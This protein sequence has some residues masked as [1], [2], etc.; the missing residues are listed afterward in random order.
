MKGIIL[1]AGRGSRLK[2]LTNNKPKCLVKFKGQ[3]LLDGIINNFLYNKIKD[4]YVVTG[5]REKKIKSSLI[6]KIYNSK[7]NK[8][9]IFKSLICCEKI[10]KKSSCIIS[11]SDIYYKRK[12]INVLK[13][14]RGD[15]CLLSNSNWKFQW[16]KRFLD[17][18]SD[19]E[20]FK[21]KKNILIDIGRKTNNIK[22]INGQYMGLIKINPRGW[23]KIMSHKK[24]YYKNKIDDLDITKFLSTFIKNK[25]N[26]V[27]VKK[28]KTEWHEIDSQKDLN[29]ARKNFEK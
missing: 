7:W 10:L 15:I 2:K 8:S 14:M 16:K 22:D 29:V 21:V 6:K 1:A 11:Y 18:L 23:K 3:T 19:L 25:N 26:K 13:S 27:F 5:Y 24:N 4:I 9:S 17:P 12:N 20:T 28:I